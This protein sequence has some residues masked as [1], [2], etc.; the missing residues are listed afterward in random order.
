MPGASAAFCSVSHAAIN[1]TSRTLVRNLALTRRAR[2]QTCSINRFRRGLM[3]EKL[4]RRTF[5][6]AAGATAAALSAKAQALTQGEAQHG[7][8]HGQDASAG[9]AGAASTAPVHYIFFR[10]DEARF[11]EAAVA[12]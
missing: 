2:L 12:R 11:V 10:P 7:P 4:T 8:G 9:A 3:M 5:F 1:A 6:K